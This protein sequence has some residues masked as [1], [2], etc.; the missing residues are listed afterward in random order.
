MTSDSET[1]YRLD[2]ISISDIKKGAN[3]LGVK[4][5]MLRQKKNGVKMR[6][7]FWVLWELLGKKGLADFGESQSICNK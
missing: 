3:K 2:T 7:S 5:N 6:G 1:Y 4:V